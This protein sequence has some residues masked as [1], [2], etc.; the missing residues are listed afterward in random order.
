MDLRV[1]RG[2]AELL[3]GGTEDGRAPYQ[4]SSAASSG[5]HARRAGARP[6]PTARG[7]GEEVVGGKKQPDGEWK[8]AAKHGELT[9]RRRGVFESNY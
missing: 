4:A 3:T 5:R 1:G 2:T 8:Q 6:A 7:D 9:G